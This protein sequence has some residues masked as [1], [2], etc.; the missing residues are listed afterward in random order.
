MKK[1]KAYA[2]VNKKKPKLKVSEI[3]EDKHVFLNKD[4]KI[5]IV[6]I[7]EIKND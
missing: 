5:I 3:Y 4:E 6:E 2:I 7:K 1:I